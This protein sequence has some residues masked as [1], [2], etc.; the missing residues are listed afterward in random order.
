MLVHPKNLSDATLYAI[1]QFVLGGG[2]GARVRRPVLRERSTAA[3][4]NN[5]MAQYM[6]QRGSAIPSCSDSGACRCRR[7][8][9][10]RTRRTTL[11]IPWN[12]RGTREMIN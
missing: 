11:P 8:R 4:S 5:P 9:S 3:G 6:A 10:P 7:T 12:V 1:D 2:K